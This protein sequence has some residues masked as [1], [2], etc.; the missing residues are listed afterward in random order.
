MDEKVV[1]T[2]EDFDL[3]QLKRDLMTKESGA[4]VI[5]NGVVRGFNEGEKVESL[6][7]ERYDGM[8]IKELEN[9]RE[10]GLNRF[11]IDDI[12]IIHRFGELDVKDNIVGIIVTSPHRKAGFEACE[13]VIDKIKE[14]VPLWK[15]E[16]TVESGEHWLEGQE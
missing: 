3:E 7:L 15:K 9:I 2:K 12:F 5:F 16:N 11:E 14:K 13:Y 8:T 10:E 1:V 6:E 4:A